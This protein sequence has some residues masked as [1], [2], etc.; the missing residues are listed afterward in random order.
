MN[1]L[2]LVNIVRLFPKF[3][4]RNTSTMK[5]SFQ[6]LASF[7][8]VF[9]TNL[10]SSQNLPIC[11]DFQE[12]EL[13]S[14]GG[15]IGTAVDDF[16]VVSDATTG[17]Q[18]LTASDASGGSS[19]Q[20]P[21]PLVGDWHKLLSKGL[22]IDLCWDVKLVN[23]GAPNSVASGPTSITIISGSGQRA[24]FNTSTNI[25]DT[26]AAG[27]PTDWYTFCAPIKDLDS[28]GNLPSNT[29][30]S[31]SLAPG[32]PNHVW[33]DILS[34][35][36]EIY[37][38]VDFLGSPDISEKWHWDNICLVESEDCG[39][40]K[41]SEPEIVACEPLDD[42]T[43]MF[44][45]NFYV[46]NLSG[47]TTNSILIDGPANFAQTGDQTMPL[48]LANGQT[49]LNP[50]TVAVTGTPGED[51]CFD[52][53]LF[54]PSS[55]GGPSIV[56]CKDE[57]C[58]NLPC[59]KVVEKEI[60]CVPGPQGSIS[61][62]ITMTLLNISN[63]P[64]N[65]VYFMDE[66]GGNVSFNPDHIDNLNVLPGDIIT[67]TTNATVTAG[68]NPILFRVT[69][70]DDDFEFC[71]DLICELELPHCDDC[72][73]IK[74][75]EF[76]EITAEE[77]DEAATL[78]N[79]SLVNG[80]LQ[81][82]AAGAINTLPYVWMAAS[83]RSTIVRINANT[84][85]VLGEYKTQPGS[86]FATGDPSRTTVDKFGECWVGNRRDINDGYTDT[87]GNN[88][89]G[90]VLRV[91]FVDGGIRHSK[92]PLG[93]FI[94]DPTGEYIIGG[95][96]S[97]SVIDRDGD[98]AIRTSNGLGNT[99]DWDLSG[100][101]IN[102]TGGV[103]AAKDECITHY[104]RTQSSQNR[105]LAIDSNNDL[106]VGGTGF[107]NIYQKI[108][109]QTGNRSDSFSI[110]GGYGALIDGNDVLWSIERYYGVHR[111]DL[112]DP[113]NLQTSIPV[114]G[115][116]G[117]GINSCT[118]SVF[119]G[120][121]KEVGA[122]ILTELD[123]AGSVI[124]QYLQPG[125]GQGLSVDNNGT[126]W[127]AEMFGNRLF[128]FDPVQPNLANSS[129]IPLPPNISGITGTAVDSNGKIWMSG[130]GT[131]NAGK[132]D[133]ITGNFSST[134][135]GD[136]THSSGSSANPY[137]YSD[138]TGKSSLSAGGQN[139]YLT[140]IHDS[141]CEDTVWG[142]VS[143]LSEISGDPNTGCSVT[144][145]VRASNDINNFPAN[146]Q[147]VNS[148]QNLC[149][150]GLIGRFIQVRVNLNRPAGCP[151][152]CD[153]KLCSLTIECCDQVGNAP[154]KISPIN[155]I[156][157]NPANDVE[158]V[159][160]R[161]TI[162]DQD[163]DTLIY[164]WYVNNQIVSV[165]R[166]DRKSTANLSYDFKSGKN[167]VTLKVTDGKA[168]SLETT[169]VEIGDHTPPSIQNIYLDSLIGFSSV[170]PDLVSKIQV[171]DNSLNVIDDKDSLTLS[172]EPKAG[173]PINQGV[174][175]V[176]ITATDPSGNSSSTLT[177]ID[178]KPVVK[179]TEPVKYAKFETGEIIKVS[180]EAGIS[181]LEIVRWEILVNGV[182][183]NQRDG[184][185]LNSVIESLPE[186]R[187]NI[188]V[189]AF[190]AANQSS[191]SKRTKIIV[192]P[193][194]NSDNQV[195]RLRLGRM[196]IEE[197]KIPLSFMAPVG[198]QCCVQFSENLEN[199]ETLHTIQGEDA[200]V[201]I[202]VEIVPGSKTGFYRL[203]LIEGREEDK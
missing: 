20:G 73:C 189:R 92:D 127:M 62:N 29:Q 171:S 121:N 170:V 141:Q 133:P 83:S 109:G 72:D 169:I 105:A 146:W 162:E 93:N 66:T 49:T 101:G 120:I 14:N 108:D 31:W 149:N 24:T 176:K 122:L 172:Q 151:P 181:S 103:S 135:L 128:R 97:P 194:S 131:N 102:N 179:I 110:L 47:T 65:D 9:L 87:N 104:V 100:S 184:N 183:L 53:I 15:W 145:E 167:L 26:D 182:V 35:V 159:L 161:S 130:F 148:G 158:N 111:V 68:I 95:T 173:T 60:V 61:Y 40:M 99:L 64:V 59:L 8:F 156:F 96:P 157:I 198:F 90:S 54:A 28:N 58:V 52:L 164:Q 4:P 22:C 30:G 46:T 138:M 41:I 174:T 117:I 196:N 79:L 17:N 154:P 144:T 50:I 200:D 115:A 69:V 191:L 178:L 63:L 143:W 199:W 142:R 203:L 177:H 155:P 13:G 37:F 197:T 114:D 75:F 139:G 36:K 153:I 12:I 43:W 21:A 136:S 67:V 129:I 113:N 2:K 106:W 193:K 165:G 123:S 16:G 27:N 185:S 132:Y 175:T 89:R 39:C 3:H 202:D 57:V 107:P 119:V 187:H 74:E 188:S 18:F 88:L 10:A 7:V 56:C 126:V 71:C 180:A 82:P 190:N 98:G 152:E 55:N 32:E 42:G 118:N 186:G 81:L 192:V 34:D 116:Y 6:I 38:K 163:E 166:A 140:V 23:D 78:V 125:E 76:N 168:E 201:K 25:S 1:S 19:V 80:K 91:G 195:P 33:T 84:G 112:S 94:A 48:V 150:S 85:D 11:T 124:G 137:N 70:H 160:I 147:P 45:Y 86:L 77:L 44:I 134:T 5:V 51:T